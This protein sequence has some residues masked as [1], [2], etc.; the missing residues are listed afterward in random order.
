MTIVAD[1]AVLVLWLAL[2]Q[3][4]MQYREQRPLGLDQESAQ[5]V[6]LVAIFLFV[7]IETDWLWR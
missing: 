1:A 7:A 5:S 3:M 2:S 6:F 4:M